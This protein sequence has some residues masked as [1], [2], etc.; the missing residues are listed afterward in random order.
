MQS[1]DDRE[2]CHPVGRSNGLIGRGRRAV[3]AALDLR[4]GFVV[5]LVHAVVVFWLLYT[6]D[7]YLAGA[8][9]AAIMIELAPVDVAPPSE[10]PPAAVPGPQM[11]EAQPEEAEQPQAIPVPELRP[12][13]KPNGRVD[14]AAQSRSRRRS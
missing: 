7:L 3:P 2:P 13:P 9:P 14:A 4:C 1:R 11:T 5:L 10:T 8:P 6:R 12:A